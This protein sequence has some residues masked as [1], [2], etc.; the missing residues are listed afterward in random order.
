MSGSVLPN[1]QLFSPKQIQGESVLW[2]RRLL[3][4]MRLNALLQSSYDL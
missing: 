2:L 4:F 3:P 1:R